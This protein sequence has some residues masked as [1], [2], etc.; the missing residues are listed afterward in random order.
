MEGGADA[1]ARRHR[2]GQRGIEQER[3]VVIDGNDDAFGILDILARQHAHFD[4][5][6]LVLLCLAQRRARQ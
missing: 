4:R 2:R 6:R 5:A 3:P 1:R